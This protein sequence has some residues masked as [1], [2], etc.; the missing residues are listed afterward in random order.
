MRMSKPINRWMS[1]IHIGGLGCSRSIIESKVDLWTLKILECFVCIL[2]CFL[3]YLLIY[4]LLLCSLDFLVSWFIAFLLSCFL[5]F[6]LSCFVA[7]LLYCFLNF[8]FSLFLSFLPSCY[9]VAK[10]KTNEARKKKKVTNEK[11]QVESSKW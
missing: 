7:L 8:L 2:C 5:H 3:A 4:L 10:S 9:L 6:W 11:F 1:V